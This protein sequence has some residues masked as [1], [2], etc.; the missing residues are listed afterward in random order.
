MTAL[1]ALGIDSLGQAASSFTPTT[2]CGSAPALVA[3]TG[4]IGDR[5]DNALMESFW[6]RVQTELL[7]PRRRRPRLEVSTALFRPYEPAG[8]PS[9]SGLP[10]ADM[11]LTSPAA[12]A[13]HR[14]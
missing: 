8:R 3:S 13:K 6:G 7:N 11:A 4:S 9:P 14:G 12:A 5:A 1:G 2:G 10:G